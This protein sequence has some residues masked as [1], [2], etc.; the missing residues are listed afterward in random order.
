MSSEPKI[1]MLSTSDINGGAAH[2]AYRIHKTVTDTGISCRLLV[3]YKGSEDTEVT[4]VNEFYRKS[5]FSEAVRFVKRKIGNKLQHARWNRYPD[6]ENVFMSDLRAGPLN[7]ALQK[8]EFDILHLHWVNLHFLDLCE[9]VK[10]NKP[11]IWTLHDCWPFTG[12]CHYFYACSKYMDACGECPLLHSYRQN[13]LSNKIW[14]QKRSIYNQLDLHVVS[15][16]NWLAREAKRSTL[17]SAFPVQVIPNPVD[18]NLFSPGELSDS[19]RA[20]KLNDTKKYI[21]FCAMNAIEDK[22]KG[23]RQLLDALVRLKIKTDITGYELLIVGTEQPQTEL[24]ESMPVTYMQVINDESLM[25]SVYRASTL[26]VVPSLS[27]NFSNVILESH[28]CGTPVVAFNIGGNSDIIEHKKTGYLAQAFKP[29]DFADGILW[30][31]ANN[32]F[33]ALSKHAREK[34]LK[35]Y[36]PEIIGMLYNKTYEFALNVEFKSYFNSLI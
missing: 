7:G 11:I 32:T 35:N 16:S 28:A 10:I 26:T 34:V 24:S 15:P 23:Y 14:K 17:M 8:I 9:L 18:T 33:G 21:L 22:N 30:C 36:T 12:I 31:L 1:L 6:K 25:A 3:L 20:L 29:D 4:T 2:S 27:E 5:A 19:C 13:D